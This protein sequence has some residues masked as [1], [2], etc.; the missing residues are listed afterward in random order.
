MAGFF[1]PATDAENRQRARNGTG[2]RLVFR[3]QSAAKT[4]FLAESQG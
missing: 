3:L 4:M 1:M 2:K